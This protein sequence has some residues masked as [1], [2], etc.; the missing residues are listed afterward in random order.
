[1]SLTGQDSLLPAKHTIQK[2][3]AVDSFQA[4]IETITGINAESGITK[5]LVLKPS[6]GPTNNPIMVIALHST[7][8]A[9]SALAK[10]LGNKDARMAQEDVVKSTFGV[11]KINGKYFCCVKSSDSILHRQCFR[12]INNHCCY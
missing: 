3:H 5:T 1:M 12:Q 9:V 4:W 8:L 10:S 2:H 11:E 6:K 7:P